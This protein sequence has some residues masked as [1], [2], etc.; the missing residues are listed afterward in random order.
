MGGSIHPRTPMLKR[1]THA[2]A[3]S[4]ALQMHKALPKMIESASPAATNVVA[5]PDPAALTL[6]YLSE[7]SQR[8]PLE[9]GPQGGGYAGTGMLVSNART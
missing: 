9:V 7:I 1:T 8:S 2:T 4:K 5:R 3:H 6:C